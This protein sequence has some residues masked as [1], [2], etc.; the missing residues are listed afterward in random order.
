MLFHDDNRHL[1]DGISQLKS[2]SE[3]STAQQRQV[4]ARETESLIGMVTQLQQ[5][6]KEKAEN[7]GGEKAS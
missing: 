7:D 4:N 5:D 3:V 6:Q 2:E 1:F